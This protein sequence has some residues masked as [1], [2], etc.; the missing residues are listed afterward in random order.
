MTK[1]MEHIWQGSRTENHNANCY[2]TQSMLAVLIRDKGCNSRSWD[3]ILPSVY[4]P[5]GSFQSFPLSNILLCCLHCNPLKQ[6]LE[7]LFYSGDTG[8]Q[9]DNG[10][11]PRPQLEWVVKSRPSSG[12][13]SPSP[14]S[15]VSQWV[16]MKGNNSWWPLPFFFFLKSNHQDIFS[17]PMWWRWRN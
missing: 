3:R 16:Q 10:A 4:L 12:S 17:K 14:K 9:G 13:P 5:L 6:E 7:P 2:N 8:S 1:G 15:G 11:C